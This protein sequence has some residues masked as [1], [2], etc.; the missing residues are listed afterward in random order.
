MYKCISYWP[1]YFSLMQLFKDW[2][3]HHH[4][5]HFEATFSLL[6]LVHTFHSLQ[7]LVIGCFVLQSM[8]YWLCCALFEIC[9]SMFLVASES[10]WKRK[11]KIFFQFLGFCVPMANM[12]AVRRSPPLQPHRHLPLHLSLSLSLSLL[13]LCCCWWYCGWII[14]CD[15]HRAQGVHFGSSRAGQR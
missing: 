11:E 10:R 4:H 13:F 7:L 5:H 14:A 15:H 3:E 6:W 1:R 12:V 2:Y 9:M 8:F